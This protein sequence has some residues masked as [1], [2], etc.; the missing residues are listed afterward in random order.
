MKRF[1]EGCSVCVFKE[2]L[3]CLYGA[4]DAGQ[5]NFYKLLMKACHAYFVDWRNWIDWQIAV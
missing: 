3:D 5:W 4:E 1:I 2:L